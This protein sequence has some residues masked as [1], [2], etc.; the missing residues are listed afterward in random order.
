MVVGV[1]E[2]KEYP[3]RRRRV[4]WLGGD[5]IDAWSMGRDWTPRAIHYQI[6]RSIKVV[7]V[8]S[9]STARTDTRAF[10]IRGAGLPSSLTVRL[11]SLDSSTRSGSLSSLKT[12]CVGRR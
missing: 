2:G 1:M 7:V 5:G 9:E 8:D 6:D 11:L 4:R 10:Y 3:R 12:S